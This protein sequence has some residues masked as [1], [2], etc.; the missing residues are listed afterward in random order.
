MPKLKWDSLYVVNDRQ[1]WVAANS[2][3]GIKS[4]RQFRDEGGM[5]DTF[6][7]FASYAEAHSFLHDDEADPCSGVS[8]DDV[9]WA[10]IDE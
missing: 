7:P 5:R 9:D 4:L 8:V 6:G 1:I 3:G 10:G 2:L